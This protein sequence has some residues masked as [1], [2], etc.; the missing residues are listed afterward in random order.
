MN[1]KPC[2]KMH[3]SVHSCAAPSNQLCIAVNSTHLQVYHAYAPSPNQHNKEYIVMNISSVHY[4]STYAPPTKL[5]PGIL[6][7]FN[8]FCPFLILYSIVLKSDRLTNDASSL[9][10]SRANDVLLLLL[11]ENN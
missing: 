11:E 7:N 9:N 5:T 2:L 8:C 4:K 1:F 3:C 6:S 10:L